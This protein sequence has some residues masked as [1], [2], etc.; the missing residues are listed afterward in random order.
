MSSYNWLPGGSTNAAVS[1]SPA[2]TTTYT[3]NVVDA[4][5]C[6]GSGY[7]IVTVN[8]NPVISAVPSNQTICVGS[9]A[10][11]TATGGTTYLWDNGSTNNPITVSPVVTTSYTVIG[12][13]LGCDGTSS[14][15]VTVDPCTYINTTEANSSD[16]NIFPNP[17][18]GNFIIDF[19]NI[20]F[21]NAEVRVYNYEGRLVLVR[22]IEKQSGSTEI[23]LSQFAKGIYNIRFVYDKSII[24]K[25]VVI[26]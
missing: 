21:E 26:Y 8:S 2:S 14:C 17:T 24:T 4:N 9:S 3:V 15:I 10:V 22:T 12:T 11:L 13:T 25:R 7:V 23:N 6:S 16:I 1:V 19:K 18:Y 20:N 5:G